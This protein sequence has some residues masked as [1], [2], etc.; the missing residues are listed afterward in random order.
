MSEE[1]IQAVRMIAILAYGSL[2][3]HPG[4]WL[5]R[6]MRSLVRCETPFGVEYLGRAQKGRGG[7]PTLIRSEG[8]NPVRGGLFVLADADTP[9][10][11]QVAVTKLAARERTT[12]LRNIRTDLE[13]LGHRVI[14]SDFSSQ[15]KDPSADELADAAIDSVAKCVVAGYPF[16]NGIRYLSENIEWGVITQLTGS[17]RAALLDKM[18]SQS[19]DEAEARL[20]ALAT[21]DSDRPRR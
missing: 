15:F 21:V 13:M 10:H 19:L 3:T 14:Y 8:S 11:L 20:I 5:G 1:E 9:Q 17:Y 12:D 16:M 18:K 2:L 6:E 4:E 7:A